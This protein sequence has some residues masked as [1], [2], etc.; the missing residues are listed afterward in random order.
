MDR[1]GGEGVSTSPAKDVLEILEAAGIGKYGKLL[2]RR[3]SRQMKDP[4]MYLLAE[5]TAS[6]NEPVHQERC[7]HHR[8][9]VEVVSGYGENGAKKG[10]EMAYGAYIKLFFVLDHTAKDGTFYPVIYAVSPPSESTIGDY[11]S[12]SFSVEMTRYI[13]G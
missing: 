3:I 4:T 9:T 2:Q 1:Q 10:S 6:P 13:G 8:V 5:T 11:T 12:Y 7:D